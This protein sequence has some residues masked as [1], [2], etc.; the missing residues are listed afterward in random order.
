MIIVTAG[1]RVTQRDILG[2]LA[3]WV[4]MELRTQ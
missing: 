1:H 2:W 4:R 3:L